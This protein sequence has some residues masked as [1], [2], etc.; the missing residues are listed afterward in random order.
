MHNKFNVNDSTDIREKKNSYNF[1]GFISKCYDDYMGNFLKFEDKK[2]NETIMGLVKEESWGIENEDKNSAR[3]IF[4]YIQASLDNCKSIS[5]GVIMFK[6]IDVYK[7]NLAIYSNILSEKVPKFSQFNVSDSNSI[8]NYFTT[9]I[10]KG[11]NSIE[12][13]TKNQI[14]SLSYI[15]NMADFCQS[16]VVSMEQEIKNIIDDDFK[17]IITLKEEKNLFLFVITNSITV[18]VNNILN[19]SKDIFL[20]MLRFDW[21]SSIEVVEESKYVK[22]LKN[23]FNEGIS[24]LTILLSKKYFS[25]YE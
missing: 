7:K 9:T 14:N 12:K 22:E 4:I 5:K 24:E 18:L 25:R 3:D 17:E 16:E 19:N 8:L 6:L 13:L 21:T 23:S 11:N 15:I 2:M 10:N 1:L 20:K